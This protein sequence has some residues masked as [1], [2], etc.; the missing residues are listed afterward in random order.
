MYTYPLTPTQSTIV[1]F[2]S[3]TVRISPSLEWVVL[4]RKLYRD[5]A[6]LE[7]C[8]PAT[9]Y[10]PHGQSDVLSLLEWRT[11]CSTDNHPLL[12]DIVCVPTLV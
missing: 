8:P 6:A 9:I 5:T 11:P 10:T 1:L 12:P 3:Y 2:V 4:R 7:I